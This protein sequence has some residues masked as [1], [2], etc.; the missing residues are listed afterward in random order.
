MKSVNFFVIALLMMCLQNAKADNTPLPAKS[1]HL[2]IS[3]YENVLGTSF[4]LKVYTAKQQEATRVEK[5]TLEEISKMSKI[6][7]SYDPNSEFSNWL[8]TYQQPI[9][10]S[11]ELFEVLNLFDEWRE[12]S[13]GAL[14]ASAAI[15]AQLW[16]Q[17]ET[18]Q[19]VPSAEDLAT[20]V[21]EVQQKHWKLDALNNTATHLTKTPLVLNSFVKSYIIKHTAAAAF[22][23]GKINAIVVNIGGDIFV[24]GDLTET[25]NIT[26]PRANAENEKP[27]DQL[28]ITNKTVAT[29][30]NYRRGEMIA[31]K[32]YSHIVD[33]RTGEPA[34]N[35]I[36]ATVVAPN[37][38]DAGALA[39]AFNVMSIAESIKLAT[40]MKDIE[41][42][43]ITKNGERIESNNWKSL[44]VPASAIEAK[45]TITTEKTI[46]QKEWKNELIINLELSEQEGY[47]KRPFAA[48]WIEDADKSAVR[49]IAL[50][51]NKPRWLRDLREWFRKNGNTLATDHTAFNSTTSATRSP[52]NYTLKWD[53][54]DDKGNVL[55]PGKYT[56]YIEAVREHGGYDLLHQEI[57][58][59]D[60]AQQ[61]NLKGNVEIAGVS[62]DYRKK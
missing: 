34:D 52:G 57:N 3:H 24:S 5:I 28:L 2:Y 27:M 4:E 61:F 42:L 23:S 32:W 60:K 39:T 54:K 58:C 59:N 13:G 16:K 18:K 46:A 6:L 51:Y 21:A 43:I 56:V 55:K 29:S 22:A 47:A 33:P 44:Q 9:H 26:D 48:I 11:N 49:T 12:R 7:S 25:V 1:V 19:Q 38:T 50:W 8:K 35:I 17:A 62:L 15:I 20:A 36:S 31:G 14:D 30:G 40:S 53:G 10:I 45:K 37:A 41:Y